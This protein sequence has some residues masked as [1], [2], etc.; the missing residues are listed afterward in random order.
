MNCKVFIRLNGSPEEAKV[1]LLKDLK[2]L[3][4]YDY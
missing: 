1:L 2:E 3:E 4:K